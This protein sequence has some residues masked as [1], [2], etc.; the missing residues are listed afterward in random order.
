MRFFE[1]GRVLYSLDTVDPWEI[2]KLL[3]PGKIVP[4]K[5]YEGRY[6]LVKNKLRVEVKFILFSRFVVHEF[7]S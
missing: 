5:V 3:R 6:F 2:A 7:Y 1:D 4:K